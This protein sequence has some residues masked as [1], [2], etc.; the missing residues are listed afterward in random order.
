MRD[1]PARNLSCVRESWI[2][3]KRVSEAQRN[4]GKAPN[5]IGFGA[6]NWTWIAYFRSIYNRN[7][8]SEL[9]ERPRLL[10]KVQMK[11]TAAGVRKY[12]AGLRVVARGTNLTAQA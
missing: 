3:D 11:N 12:R 5:A 1:V 9:H 2:R 4:D 10:P 7:Q 6:S 8:T